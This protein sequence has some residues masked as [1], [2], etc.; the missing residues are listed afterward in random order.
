MKS[1]DST[2]QFKIS[3]FPKQYSRRDS[4]S[5]TE[6]I[7]RINHFLAQVARY[8]SLLTHCAYYKFW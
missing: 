1:L 5:K 6:G 8:L 3:Y 7:E 4:E 2:E